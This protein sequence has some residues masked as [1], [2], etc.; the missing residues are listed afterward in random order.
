MIFR[1]WVVLLLAPVVFLACQWL[2][3]VRAARRN[4][5]AARRLRRDDLSDEEAL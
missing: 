4:V 1:S 5:R 3:A 2:V